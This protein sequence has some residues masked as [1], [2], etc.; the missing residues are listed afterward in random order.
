[1][2]PTLIIRLSIFGILTFLVLFVYFYKTSG[3]FRQSVTSAVLATFVF[4]GWSFESQAKNVN[5]FSPQQQQI[6]QSRPSHRSGFFSGRSSNDG[7][8]PGKPD[9]F[10]SDSGGDGLPKLPETE[11]MEK[12]EER[13]ENIE[14]LIRRMEESLDTETEYESA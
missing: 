9:D 1:L 13:V 6:H 12:T 14:T 5:A 3:K 10:D 11:C 8:E 7:S 4:F 2:S